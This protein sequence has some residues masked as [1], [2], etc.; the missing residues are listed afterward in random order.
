MS[1]LE[2]KIYVGIDV[3]KT[4]LDI[5][6][7]PQNKAFT[8]NNDKP[9]VKK[10]FK[11][12]PKEVILIVLEATGGYEKAVARELEK[13]KLPISVINPRQARDFAKALGQL[14]KTDKIDSRILALFAEKIGPS[15]RLLKS[16]KLQA[17]S[18]LKNR[19]RQLLDM[20]TMEKNRLE[21]A[22]LTIKR[23]ITKTIKFL[24]KEL[25]EIDEKLVDA[26]KE[27][28]ELSRKDQLLRSI[29]GV[30]PVLSAT[31]LADLPELGTTTHKKISA[32]VGVAPFNRDSGTFVGGR[33]I[34]GG[35][36]SVR[37]TLYMA[38]LAAIK[39]NSKLKTFY[40]HLCKAGKAK[41]VALIACMHKLLMIMN[42]ILK[43]GITWKMELQNT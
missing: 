2:Q 43:S 31:L 39:S 24:Q 37:A 21:K 40:Q 6:I 9:G 14:A 41:K 7:L 22:S 5:Y 18:D 42:A 10:L 28:A 29:N 36:A 38:T 25:N 33:T 30:G 3:S 1:E 32:L 11:V 17:L 23:I 27:D 34:W 16:A 20:I 35:R 26:I 13:A 8:V 4:N 19:R 15:P 12:L